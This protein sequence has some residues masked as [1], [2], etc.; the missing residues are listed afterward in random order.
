MWCAGSHR[1]RHLAVNRR[2][3]SQSADS[4][5]VR[6]HRVPNLKVPKIFV[7]FWDKRGPCPVAM[8]DRK[9]PPLSTLLSSRQTP[10]DHGRFQRAAGFVIAPLAIDKITGKRKLIGS[11]VIFAQHL[12][13]QAR[14]RFPSAIE[15]SQSSVACCHVC[16]PL[17]AACPRRIPD[18]PA[19]YCC[20]PAHPRNHNAG[21][22]YQCDNSDAA[23][24]L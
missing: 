8:L 4:G 2:V 18:P 23:R 10:P 9:S 12:N 3:R 24:G 22:R 7:A 17:S 11:A 5:V 19:R 15:F 6:S 16:S 13:R 20:N 1:S 21:M 14:R